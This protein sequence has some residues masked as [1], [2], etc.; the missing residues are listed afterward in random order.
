[1]I[2]MT[3]LVAWCCILAMPHLALYDLNRDGAT[4]TFDYD[5]GHMTIAV[6]I[7]ALGIALSLGFTNLPAHSKFLMVL[8]GAI[9][10]LGAWIDRVSAWAPDILMLP[11]CIAIFLASPEVASLKTAGIALGLGTALFL[12]CIALWVPQDMFNLKFAPPADLMSL[13]APFVL[14]GISMETAVIFMVVSILLVLALKSSR[15]AA[16]LS[17]PEAV[18]DGARDVEFTEKKAVTFLSVIFPVI[19]VA[20][21]AKNLTP[22]FS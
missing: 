14:F 18:A 9:L 1:M 22:M 10:M 6:G 16:L 20:L 13:A 2:V 4:E 3:L 17:R 12:M 8:I 11:F 7:G 5:F 19:F 15:F 21:V